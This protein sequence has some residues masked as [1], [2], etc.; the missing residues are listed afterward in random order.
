MLDKKP[1]YDYATV[2]YVSGCVKLVRTG[3]CASTS[4]WRSSGASNAHSDRVMDQE[5][6]GAIDREASSPHVGAPSP[7][8]LTLA[9]LSF[10]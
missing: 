2:D 3:S 9:H 8:A 5:E 4:P 6:V 10:M 1:S 7:P